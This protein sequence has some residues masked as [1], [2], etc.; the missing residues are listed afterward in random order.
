MIGQRPP[1]LNAGLTPARPILKWAGGKTQLLP[2][3][4]YAMPRR[5]RRY[6][7]P[8]VGAGAL[9]F[10]LALPGS[11]ASDSNADLIQF[12]TVVRDRPGELLAA[13]SQLPISEDDYYRIRALD[14][15]SLSPVERAARF[16]YL[17]KTCYNG[18]RGVPTPTNEVEYCANTKP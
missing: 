3:L 15:N 18:L 1:L 8:F 7:E 13:T 9:L 2:I 14:P 16:L 17:N 10:D 4:R 11:L 6:V 12:Y 5:F